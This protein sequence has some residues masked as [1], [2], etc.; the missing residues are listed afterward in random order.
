M[1]GSCLSNLECSVILVSDYYYFLFSF[2]SKCF[3]S[4]AQLAHLV[5]E[6]EG[7]GLDVDAADSQLPQSVEKE[8]HLTDAVQQHRDSGLPPEGLEHQQNME[9]NHPS[10]V[11]N[12]PL[13]VSVE[14]EGLQSVMRAGLQAMEADQSSS[15][16]PVTQPQV[17]REASGAVMFTAPVMSL[18]MPLNGDTSQS[19]IV[20]VTMAQPQQP[21]PST[22]QTFTTLQPVVSIN[23][24]LAAQ[25]AIS[26]VSMENG[27][28]TVRSSDTGSAEDRTTSVQPANRGSGTDGTVT[29]QLM[30][31]AAK[32][33]RIV[34]AQS[35]AAGLGT[36]KTEPAR[37]KSA[38][39]AAGVDAPQSHLHGSSLA[40]SELVEISSADVDSLVR[41]EI[42]E[43]AGHESESMDDVEE[44]EQASSAGSS[45]SRWRRT[46][47]LKL[48]ELYKE[49]QGF[50]EDKHYKKKT[51]CI[52]V[53]DLQFKKDLII[54]I[55]LIKKKK[56]QFQ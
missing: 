38:D 28:V 36:D 11:R 26:I 23:P 34:A 40:G 35:V 14:A 42:V 5:M 54:I 21:T 2:C 44:S 16:V 1:T 55:I 47:T 27:I 8:I 18:T 7:A 24:L 3:S 13:V 46:E 6:M 15:A 49:Y 50:F 9:T 32:T 39:P 52:L 51:V 25:P 30:D 56:N 10:A 53:I 19:S 20:T 33:D 31:V 22:S 4:S 29:A 41:S 48:V 45:S 37:G 12:H 17:F 43:D